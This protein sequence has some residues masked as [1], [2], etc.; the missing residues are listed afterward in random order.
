M[1][2]NQSALEQLAEDIDR[3]SCDPE[4]KKCFE[5]KQSE[6]RKIIRVTNNGDFSENEA[7]EPL[8]GTL[9]WALQQTQKKQGKYEIRFSQSP[10]IANNSTKKGM[11]KWTIE[12]YSPLPNI[13]RSDIIVNY[14]TPQDIILVP[15][16]YADQGKGDD[17]HSGVRISQTNQNTSPDDEKYITAPKTAPILTVGDINYFYHDS[18]TA[19][20]STSPKDVN[21]STPSL[22]LNQVNFSSN[23]AAGGDAINGGGGGLGAGGGIVHLHGDLLI[24]NAIFQ[25]LQAIGGRGKHRSDQ[26][27]PDKFNN[28]GDSSRYDSME[29]DNIEA[30]IMGG[31]GGMGGYYS[32]GG[33]RKNN[34][35][36]MHPSIEKKVANNG[37]ILKGEK[38]LNCSRSIFTGI[39]YCTKW[40][41]ETNLNY[42]Y[43]E[44]GSDGKF[45]F[46]GGGGAGGRGAFWKW[47]GFQETKDG[48][49]GYALIN[50]QTSLDPNDWGR[51]GDGGRGGFGGGGGGG[52]GGGAAILKKNY[53]KTLGITNYNI[54]RWQK[55]GGFAGDG[56]AGG[57]LAQKGKNGQD[58][59]YPERKPNW[60][61][62]EWN[63]GE[64]GNDGDDNGGLGGHG[65]NGAALGGSIALLGRNKQNL[66]LKNVKF[67]GSE[68]DAETDDLEKGRTIFQDY[69]FEQANNNST[70]RADHDVEIIDKEIGTRRLN[71]VDNNH[72]E[73][74]TI[75]AQ[76]EAVTNSMHQV[77]QQRNSIPMNTKYVDFS[78]LNRSIDNKSGI[79]DTTIINVEYSTSHRSIDLFTDLSSDDNPLNELF[80][81]ATP[82]R[83]DSINEAHQ[84]ALAQAGATA[85][86]T[87]MIKGGSAAIKTVKAGYDI[88]KTAKNAGATVE[89]LL[90]S[91][92]KLAGP[93]TSG[94]LSIADP[95]LGLIFGEM[96][97]QRKIA[98]AHNTH[99][100]DLRE[101][102]E[103]QRKLEERLNSKHQSRLATLDLQIDKERTEVK[104][105]NFTLGED[106]IVFEG[107]PN[108][109]SFEVERASGKIHL[110]VK[111][112]SGASRQ[113][114]AQVALSTQS[115]SDSSY[116]KFLPDDVLWKKQDQNGS[117]TWVWGVSNP[118][119]PITIQRK[120]P[121]SFYAPRARN[122]L[123]QPYAEETD[124]HTSTYT[125]N[126]DDTIRAQQSIVKNNKIKTNNGEDDIYPGEGEDTIDGGAGL[127][128][129]S[130]VGL[131]V[132]IEI[133]ATQEKLQKQT[134]VMVDESETLTDQSNLE[135]IEFFEAFGPSKIN[136]QDLNPRTRSDV[137]KMTSGAG[138]HLQ[139]SK[140]HD[141]FELILQNIDQD[142]LNYSIK[143]E[144]FWHALPKGGETD[145]PRGWR[146]KMIHHY[147]TLLEQ[148][149]E[150]NNPE[151]P[152]E[153]YTTDEFQQF[154]TTQPIMVVGLD[155]Q[156][157]QSTFREAYGFHD[158]YAIPST[159]H[160]PNSLK[161]EFKEFQFSLDPE[162]IEVVQFNKDSE[163]Y[164]KEIDGSLET[165][166]ST[167]SGNQGLDRLMTSFIDSPMPI[168][169]Q[170]AENS[171][172]DLVGWWNANDDSVEPLIRLHDIEVI[173]VALSEHDDKIDT[174]HWRHD[175]KKTFE[176]LLIDGRAGNDTIQGGNGDD[177]LYGGDG[178]DQLDGFSGNDWIEGNQGVDLID[179]GSGIDHLF[180][181]ADNDTIYGSEHSDLLEG[182]QGDDWLNGGSGFDLLVGGGGSDTLNGGKTDQVDRDEFGTDDYLLGKSGNDILIALDGS[183]TLKGGRGIDHY[184]V[185]HQTSITTIK[186]FD[187]ESGE[188]LIISGCD[189]K[190]V[191]EIQEG[192]NLTIKSNNNDQFDV[193]IKG[194]FEPIA[195]DPTQPQSEEDIK[196]E[197]IQELEDRNIFI[198]PFNSSDL[199]TSKSL[200]TIIA[201]SNSNVIHC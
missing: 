29:E 182:N 102:R 21:L 173:D 155:R 141:V 72:F 89:S 190:R 6:A 90:K 104:I 127:D 16:D 183:D 10:K 60:N 124:Q 187:Y 36:I 35:E 111:G 194:G 68:V 46:G 53:H 63:G 25:R 140:Y 9:R 30:T 103:V 115:I 97:R 8:V 17:H 163:I 122:I 197:V 13:Y 118:N 95:I 137:Y 134:R 162:I 107:I 158:F 174:N 94:L 52:G 50:N 100:R 91:A 105:N 161:D 112:S 198:H 99:V 49:N 54:N 58:S 98:E 152:N 106:V 96:E 128:L 55:F 191:N 101:N 88:Y 11:N 80:R 156:E 59:D 177:G 184:I 65:G 164:T 114:V 123:I 67:I 87:N 154:L 44:D 121:Q 32:G 192:L 19:T 145:L 7:A 41:L 61:Q 167:V 165:I 56:A 196:R 1:S 138:S 136:L 71:D 20:R 57:P 78:K 47:V 3:I 75:E 81:L 109:F 42:S 179:G 85:Q 18:Q 142:K 117:S 170:H 133:T 175:E 62:W 33:K 131:G 150:Q 23:T 69:D 151:D 180:G 15:Y 143:S 132:P 74:L 146:E 39:H 168:T 28:G 130:Y 14:S 193:I 31:K 73:G 147:K 169:A 22:K 83:T 45:G 201:I 125:G 66:V 119:G 166:V 153:I 159:H 5:A 40:E 82:D 195:I 171:A 144:D 200:S 189:L 92:G 108:D 149:I 157:S 129:V 48:G 186:Q 148:F 178:D 135:N 77:V 43:G 34:G 185:D 116:D 176:E 188:K 27:V 51:G 120:T 26:G 70:I 172:E 24:E 76:R 181:G 139:G 110:Y 79:N 37:R 160:Q 126:E 84:S 2:V 199:D 93:I 12:L 86:N 113:P 38:T 64:P 4:S